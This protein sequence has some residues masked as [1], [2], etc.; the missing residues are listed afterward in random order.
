MICSLCGKKIIT[1]TFDKEEMTICDE[2]RESKK[3]KKLKI[4]IKNTKKDIKNKGSEWKDGYL[5]GLNKA[6]KILR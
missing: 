4:E 5:A 3:I 6:L 2:C 1:D